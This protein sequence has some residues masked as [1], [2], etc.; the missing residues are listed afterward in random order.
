MQINLRRVGMLYSL[1]L[2]LVF[3]A[4][5]AL[6]IWVAENIGWW[7]LA[8]VFGTTLFGLLF[9]RRGAR[10]AWE[11]L[12][13]AMSDGVMPAGD[14]GKLMFGFVGALLLIMPGFLGNLV[15]LVLLLPPTRGLIRRLVGRFSTGITPAATSGQVIRGDVV[16]D[17]VHEG[18][19]I[20]P[21]L[22]PGED[23]R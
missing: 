10:K 7:T 4:E 12:R 11:Q 14:S 1:G 6:F 2:L 20:P 5:F 8:V 22:E 9:I 21:A 3:V 23:D 16:D 19:I 13:T 15:G 18:T 17:D